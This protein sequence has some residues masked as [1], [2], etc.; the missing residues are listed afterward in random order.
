M[1]LFLIVRKILSIDCVRAFISFFLS[2]MSGA[3]LLSISRIAI[4]SVSSASSEISR[5]SHSTPSV[6]YGLKQFIHLYCMS[7]MLSEIEESF[8]VSSFIFAVH[9]KMSPFIS[10]IFSERVES[11][12][13]FSDTLLS[14]FF[15][16]P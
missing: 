15:I 7:L 16:S 9:F 4:N 14:S 5:I 13:L 1:P 12:S 11:L 10:E 3:F 2:S 6:K 8:A